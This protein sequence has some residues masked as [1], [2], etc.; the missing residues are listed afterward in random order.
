MV[1]KSDILTPIQT[2]CANTER[3]FDSM[4]HDDDGENI[5]AENPKYNE[6][7]A[8]YW[9]WKNYDKLGKSD[10]IGFMRYRRHFCVAQKIELFILMLD[11]VKEVFSDYA[12][13]AEEI[14]SGHIKYIAD[15]PII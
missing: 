2:G 5:S 3:L 7:S 6:L 4:L 10:Y 8:Q 14:R 15:M 9:A 11:T 12:D 1:L 13:T